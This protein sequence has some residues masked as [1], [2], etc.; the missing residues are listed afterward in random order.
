MIRLKAHGVIEAPVPSEQ[1]RVPAVVRGAQRVLLL[2]V[3]EGDA[4]RAVLSQ[5]EPGRRQA[6]HDGL[7]LRLQG[8]PAA[9]GQRSG[10][11]KEGRGKESHSATDHRLYFCVIV[12]CV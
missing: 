7:C 1:I 12:P 8:L 2:D 5:D 9:R 4:D 11:G 10:L 6:R 3:G